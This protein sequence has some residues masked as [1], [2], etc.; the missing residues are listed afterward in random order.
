MAGGTLQQESPP[1]SKEEVEEIALVTEALAHAKN[2][3]LVIEL[4]HLE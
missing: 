2:E 1:T 4:I 3:S